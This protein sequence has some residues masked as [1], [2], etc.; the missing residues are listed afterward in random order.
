MAAKTKTQGKEITIEPLTRIEGH[1]AVHATADND[2]KKY[3]DA[4]SYG[5]MFRGF[6]RILKGREP[7]DAIWITQRIC[8]VCPLPHATASAQ[9]IDMTYNVSPPPVGIALRNFTLMSEELYDSPLGCAILEGPDYSAQILGKYAPDV[10]TRARV[11]KAEHAGLHGYA[12]I[13][14]IAEGLNP[15]TGSI[16]LRALGMSKLGRK[17]ASLLAG[18]HPHVNSFVPGGI[19]KTIR[20]SDLEQYASML[21]QHVAFSKE[22]VPLFDD[23]INFMMPYYGENGVRA[24]NMMAMGCYE[25]LS[26][27][28]AQYEDMGTWG[29]KRA[30]TPGVVIDGEI[31]TNDLIEINLGVREYVNHS[32][33]EDWSALDMKT[34]PAGNALDKNHPWNEQTIA[35]PGPAK[36]WGGKYTWLKAPRWADSKG[37][38]HVVEVGP[39]ARMY[40]TAK[41]K[42]VDASTGKSLKFTLPNSKIMGARVPGEM[43][44]EWKIPSKINTL[45]RIRARAYFHA[46]TAHVAYNQLL[47][48]LGAV[49]AGN[50]KVWTKYERPKDGVGCGLN[51]AMR[52]AVAH[53][54][55]MKD[56]KVQKYQ[57]IAPT[58]WNASPRGPNEEPGPYEEAIIGTP[59]TEKGTLDGLDVVR[60]IRGFDP[61]LACAIH[62]YD[63]KGVLKNKET[64]GCQ[65]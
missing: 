57:I 22:F 35:K 40:T 63:G 60:V 28:N 54:C 37:K 46:Y 55:I 41:S 18:K 6:E 1:L 5:T 50:T 20:A 51:E 62:T 7:A 39:V 4:H 33:Y 44:F 19:G 32:Y 31:V 3:T 25:D 11:T 12:T 21:F 2:G 13:G 49:K 17:M 59:I 14:D 36:N 10:L 27:Y 23:L 64:L 45:E 8:G 38:T 42:K 34:D 47:V 65:C 16:W 24:P 58:T 9:C 15:I 48:A 29:I 30:V 61:C 26:A 52:G 53:W 43:E 56:G